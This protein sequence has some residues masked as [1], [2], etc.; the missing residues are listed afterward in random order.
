M[1]GRRKKRSDEPPDET[2]LDL[3]AMALGA[4]AGAGLVAPPE[5]P[6]V[7][8]VVVDIPSEGGFATVVAL[9]DNTT[10]MYT[11]TG[12]GTIG[13]GTHASVAAA[14]RRLLLVAEEHL[15]GFEHQDDPALPAPGVVRIH[16]LN[17]SGGRHAD[18]PDKAFWGREPHTLTP[19][20]S[21]VQ[22]VI[23]AMRAA[24]PN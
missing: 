8:G 23:T 12:G 3:R 19:L 2:F 7:C 6:S 11:S 13:A 14:T 17:A 16:A 24:S 10:S 18:I 1:F 4:V 9:T 21:S 22:G 20:I 15:G 5:H